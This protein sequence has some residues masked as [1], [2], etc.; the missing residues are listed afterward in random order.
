MKTPLSLHLS[1]PRLLP[2]T[3]RLL[4][5][6]RHRLRPTSGS[7]REPDGVAMLMFNVLI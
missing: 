1:R 6:Y 4:G 3:N 5:S 7:S 2:P